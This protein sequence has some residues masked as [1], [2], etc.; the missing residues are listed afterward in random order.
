MVFLHLSRFRGFVWDA[1]GLVKHFICVLKVLFAI[2]TFVDGYVED[3]N[4]VNPFTQRNGNVVFLIDPKIIQLRSGFTLEVDN[5]I[6]GENN[7]YVGNYLRGNVG[8]TIGNFDYVGYD[9]GTANVSGLSIGDMDRLFRGLT[10][11]DFEERRNTSYTKSNEY[12]NLGLPSIQN[13]VAIYTGASGAVPGTVDVANTAYFPDSGHLYY[14][15]GTNFGV[16]YYSGR[17]ATQFLGCVSVNGANNI[18][19][20]SEI[21]P[22][23]ME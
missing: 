19:T 10:I 1:L 18:T 23:V 5:F 8:P 21:I 9:D 15:D 22:M 20:T 16:I 17:T 11:T 3:V 2:H 4:I 12:F 7:E 14:S 6:F 13:P